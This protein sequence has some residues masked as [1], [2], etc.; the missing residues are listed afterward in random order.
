MAFRIFIPINYII[1]NLFHFLFQF[2][3]EHYCFCTFGT[4]GASARIAQLT[5]PLNQKSASAAGKSTA[6]VEVMER[7][8][9]TSQCITL[10]PGFHDVCLNQHVLEV[11]ALGLKTKS[12]KSYRVLYDQGRKSQSE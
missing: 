10:H 4:A 1:R 12:G 3:F 2:I 8:G 5:S 9:D 11:A 6:V 7:F